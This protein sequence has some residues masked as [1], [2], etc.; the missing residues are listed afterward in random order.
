[1]QAYQRYVVGAVVLLL[2][3]WIVGKGA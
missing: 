1:V 2:V 3:A